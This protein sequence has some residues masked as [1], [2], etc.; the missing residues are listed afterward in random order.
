MMSLS[1]LFSDLSYRFRALF[2]RGKMDR[3]LDDELRFHLE[4]ETEKHV[5]AGMSPED[6][7][8]RARIEFGGVESA[9]EASRDGRGL[10]LLDLLAQD[11]R[12]A[13]RALR[14]SPGFTLAVVLTLGLGI[15]ANAAMFGIVDRL[16]FRTPA[17]LR[18]PG[19]VH[20]IYLSSIR[21]GARVTDQTT[22]YTRF[23]DLQRE[24]TR[25]SMMAGYSHRTMPVGSGAEAREMPV[26]TVSAR[27]FDFFDAPPV[28]GRYF[29]AE[30]DTVPAGAAVAVLGYGYWQAQYGGRPD[31]LGRQ[32]KIGRVDFTVI[33]VAPRRFAGIADGG[34]PVAFIPITTYAATFRGSLD[35]NYY[36]RY[37]WGW[38][39]VLA[40]R[41]PGVTLAEANADLTHAFQRSWDTEVSLSPG[42]TPASVAKPEAIAGPVQ[43]ERGPLQSKVTKVATWVSAVTL[44]VLVIACANVANL[45]L[46]RAIGRRREI[47]VRLAMGVS[48]GRLALQ[49]LT[50]SLVLALL[51]GLA[52]LLVARGGS[53]VLL[54]LFLP[55]GAEAGALF[56][57][58]TLAFTSLVALG[59]AV[60]TGLAPILQSRR[61]NVVD[62]LKAGAREGVYR[63]SRLRS[64]LLLLQAALSVVLLVGAGLFV[65]SLRNVRE[66]RLG[67]D[68]DP[69]LYIRPNLR[70]VQLSDPE[71]ARLRANLAEAAGSI[72]GVEAAARGLTVPFWDTW[73]QS[74]FVAGIDSVDRLGEFTIQA[75]D[76]SYF[77]TLGTRV[78]RG[79]G[80]TAADTRD[81][82]PVAVITEAMAHTLWPGQDALGQC[83]RMNADTA[84]CTTIVGITEDV[85]QN[86]LTDDPGLHY[87]LPIEQFHPEGAVVFA[88]VRGDAEAMRET[89]RRRLQPLM[90]GDAYVTVTPMREIVGERTASW[91][92][93]TTMFLAFG[94]L[95]L[96]LAAIG[97]YSVIAY[98]VAQRRRELGVRI[99]LGARVE[100]LVRLVV[101]DGVRVALLGLLLGGCLALSAAHWIEPLLF[102]QSP[103]D[104]VVF[105][106]VTAILL[107]AA[108]VASLLPALRA[109]RVDPNG[110]LRGE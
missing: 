23:L 3:E 70:G 74:L 73:S 14:R 93:G 102:A 50:E 16:L 104:P 38:M 92:A 49:L 81:A 31:V 32:L 36:T 64:G 51:G 94:G 103:R 39:N 35:P 33:G 59:A 90:P 71:N 22:E 40:R 44:I 88:R 8:R 62:S 99:A 55:D 110:V 95:A 84:P 91:E 83:M 19:T 98:D 10:L 68:V 100:H 11:L 79:R 26:G 77:H 6:A 15:G 65:R 107:A 53:A 1:E 41:K 47:A 52:G 9:K 30:E 63:R 57:G 101:G 80:I 12:Y 5:R 82:A 43:L 54:S 27:Y 87:Y 42:M 97:L 60:L 89:V 17:Y 67:Y 24:T 34:A 4:R 76:S 72:P 108:L 75:G 86:G 46:A 109:A 56:D 96:V 18:D 29:T 28:L 66:L 2:R 25:F 85:K 7:A 20:R 37:N 61:T 106:A 21:R 13:F 45:L 105:G 58:R 48:R 78:L 69:V